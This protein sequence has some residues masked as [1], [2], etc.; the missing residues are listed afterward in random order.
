MDGSFAA[1]ES[2][3]LNPTAQRSAH[4]GISKAG[5]IHQYVDEH[6]TAFH[7]GI[8]VNPS[9]SLLKPH[10]NPNF[11][12]IGI[13]HEGLA[14]DVWPSEQLSASAELV[15][16]IAARWQ[17]PLDPLHV[18]RHH[19]IRASKS[20]PGN[21]LRDTRTL[22]ALVPHSTSPTPTPTAT[23][24]ALS[25]VNLRAAP[26]TRA[27]IIRVIPILTDVAINGFVAGERVNAN[28]SWYVDADGNYLW[29]GATDM[30]TPTARPNPLKF[31]GRSLALSRDGLTLATQSLSVQAPEIWSLMAVETSGCGFLPDRRPQILFERHVFHRLTGGH[32]DDG[33]I[34]D[35]KPGGYGPGGAH[36]YDRLGRA[37]ALDRP[38]ALQ[39]T[40]WGLGQIMG[41]NFA[42]AGFADVEAMV[43]AMC[44]S[45]DAQLKAVVAFLKAKGLAR[46]LRAHD[47][48]SFALGY[49]GP[50]FAQN[51]YDA[52]LK[53]EFQKYSSGGVMPDLDI[54]AAQLYLSFCRLDPGPVDGLIGSR[55]RAALA[56]FQ[57]KQQL[58]T[59][60]QVDGTVLARL[61]HVALA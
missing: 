58:P 19:Q 34:S 22:L 21:W 31:V 23:V 61:V 18:I 47:W 39:S 50:N 20:C 8:V 4:Y 56:D 26:N 32:F 17:I 10:V 46:A 45:E 30:P 37:A 9:W 40:S 53:A 12:T 42:A 54:R 5:D 29:A 52:K 44:D 43:G 51:R 14:D 13:E 25:A 48:S 28:S 7:A 55:T 49:N 38:A 16:Q 33:D 36:Q 41:E 11:Y 1:G 24:R 2:V 60:G 15:G 57:T 27:P 6:D 3:F 59:T 35:P